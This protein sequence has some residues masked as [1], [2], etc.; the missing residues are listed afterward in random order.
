V[1]MLVHLTPLKN[2]PTIRRG[3]LS[4]GLFAF[5]VLPSYTLTHQWT[6]ELVKWKRQPMVGVY[7]LI[8]DDALVR[9]GHYSKGHGM[10]RAAEAVFDVHNAA[11][12]RGLEIVLLTRVPPASIHRIA[13]VRAVV[14]WR[15]M[16]DAHGRAPCGCPACVM[17]GEP[18]RQKLRA[19]YERGE[20]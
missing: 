11:D 19:R 8:A 1:V 9:I 2:A 15:H 7:F 20:I 12:S 10:T 13:P 4:A 16:P 5:P 18:G 6:R 17:R 14:G 3:G